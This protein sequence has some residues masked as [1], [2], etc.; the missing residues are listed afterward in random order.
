VRRRRRDRRRHIHLIKC[1]EGQLARLETAGLP[2]CRKR[3]G[4]KPRTRSTTRL[5]RNRSLRLCAPDNTKPKCLRRTIPGVG[6]PSSQRL[7]GPRPLLGGDWH[8]YGSSSRLFARRD[9]RPC[10][11]QQGQRCPRDACARRLCQPGHMLPPGTGIPCRDHHR[12]RPLAG[13]ACQGDLRGSRPPR[14]A[15]NSPSR[16]WGRLITKFNSTNVEQARLRKRGW[17][18]YRGANPCSAMQALNVWSEAI[19]PAIQ[20]RP[21]WTCV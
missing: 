7:G 14:P 3:G 21:A 13:R 15:C 17:V 16:V 4:S 1:P 10:R 11:L 9:T 20:R 2:V 12:P 5:P 19:A 18:F 8:A 6:S